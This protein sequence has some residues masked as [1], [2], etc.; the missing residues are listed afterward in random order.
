MARSG[1]YCAR[2]AEAD[3]RRLEDLASAPAP[4]LIADL[5]DCQATGR[6][7]HPLDVLSGVCPT[8][9]LYRR[10]SFRHTLALLADHSHLRAAI[11]V[12]ERDRLPS[13]LAV[14]RCAPH[15][16]PVSRAIRRLT[17]GP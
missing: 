1:C 2:P 8:R 11:G 13:R 4:R 12:E 3:Q 9:F 16:D 15:S 17:Q 7:G 14:Y 6:K 5:R 10:R